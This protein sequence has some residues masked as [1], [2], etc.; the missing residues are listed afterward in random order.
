MH[1]DCALAATGNTAPRAASRSR[2]GVW[3]EG[4]SG[5]CVGTGNVPLSWI[6]FMNPYTGHGWSSDMMKITLGFVAGLWAMA[7]M[8]ERAI[9]NA[10]AAEP[11]TRI[12]SST[13]ATTRGATQVKSGRSNQDCDR[14]ISFRAL[15][16][17]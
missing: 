15:N 13:R 3:I 6:F 16:L 5:C 17:P 4:K 8:G 9:V 7:R 1:L 10:R 11:P 2:F 14:P 12:G